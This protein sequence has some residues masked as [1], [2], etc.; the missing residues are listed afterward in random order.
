LHSS[1]RRYELREMV[2]WFLRVLRRGPE[3]IDSTNV[4]DMKYMPLN[5]LKAKLN[6]MMPFTPVNSITMDK[7]ERVSDCF[8]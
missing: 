3:V 2:E 4:V 7:L 8:L 5:L 6:E 1:P